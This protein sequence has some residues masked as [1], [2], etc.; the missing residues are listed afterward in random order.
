[1]VECQRDAENKS[2][3]LDDLFSGSGCVSMGWVP[4]VQGD[5]VR[6]NDFLVCGIPIILIIFAR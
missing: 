6:D 3:K 4:G 5:G 2:V 1:M